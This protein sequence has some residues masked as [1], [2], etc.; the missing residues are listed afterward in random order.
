MSR[1][2]DAQR[3]PSREWLRR[4]ADAEDRC[5]SV[6]AGGLAHDVGL[7]RPSPNAM[8]QVFGRLI[9]FARRAKGLSLEKLAGDAD[10]SLAELIRI[11]RDEET[12]P[13]P[14]TVYKLAEVLRLPAG[15]LME[16]SGLAEAKDAQLGEAALRFAARSRP[17]VELSTAEREALEQFVKVLVETSD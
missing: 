14:R 16:I 13:T 12:I 3:P 2:V 7:L 15:R 5:D 1:D 6:V 8:P 9:G 11:E 10:V 4:T 17:T